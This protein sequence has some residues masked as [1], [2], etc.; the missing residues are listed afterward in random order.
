[1]KIS[2]FQMW[3]RKDAFFIYSSLDW[4]WRNHIR[5]FFS[6]S[7]RYLP[8]LDI[9]ELQNE[10]PARFSLFS[11]C[12]TFAVHKHMRDRHQANDVSNVTYSGSVSGSASKFF[13]NGL[14]IYASRKT[15]SSKFPVVGWITSEV[16][17]WFKE[18][19]KP[20]TR[21]NEREWFQ[22]FLA[23]L[24]ANERAFLSLLMFRKS[25]AVLKNIIFQLSATPSRDSC[26]SFIS[27]MPE[28][29][30]CQKPQIWFL[31]RVDIL[32]VF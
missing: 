23:T 14:W 11:G 31:S 7:S 32:M 3:R 17:K 4:G 18:A 22:P 8:L 1:M 12:H 16:R 24:L 27:D 6:F 21:S 20:I 25:I 29:S 9:Y 10:I 2:N 19:E 13:G 26:R 30:E 15:E 28:L 5:I